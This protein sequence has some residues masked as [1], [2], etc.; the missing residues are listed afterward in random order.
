VVYTVNA[1]GYRGELLAPKVSGETR[2][3]IVGDSFIFGSLLND[4]DTLPQQLETCLAES[5]GVGRVRVVNLGVPGYQIRQLL[6]AMDQRLPALDPDIVL[7]S[8]YVNDAIGTP[9]TFEGEE[10]NEDLPPPSAAKAW[11]RR[12]GLTSPAWPPSTRRE[13]LQLAIRKRSALADT[14]ARK[15]FTSLEASSRTADLVHLWREGGTGWFRILEG[16]EQALVLSRRD[17]YELHVSMYPSL[18]WIGNRRYPLSDAHQRMAEACRS[19]GLPFHD[20]HPVL[21]GHE[22]RSLW[23]HELDQHPNAACNRLVAQYLA[24]ELLPVLNR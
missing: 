5:L 16:L 7:L 8:L 22:P 19:L 20:I 9:A 11:I 6:A 18:A 15:L 17:G 2:V 10:P 4:G 21:A 1:A 13:R 24:G 14:V 3:A 12:L 23:A